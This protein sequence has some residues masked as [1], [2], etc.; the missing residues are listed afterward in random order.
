MLNLNNTLLLNSQWVKEEI[1]SEIQRHLEIDANENT[2]Y[3]NLQ[4]VTIQ[5]D[6]YSCKCMYFKKKKKKK[7]KDFN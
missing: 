7:K 2:T 4:D 6:T 1:T 3:N 5:R